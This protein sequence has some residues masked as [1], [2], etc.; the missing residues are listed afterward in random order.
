[1]ASTFS[2]HVRCPQCQVI[3]QQLHNQR[4]VLVRLLTQSVQLGNRVV[5]RRLRQS[6]RTVWRV[7]NLVVKHREVECQPEPDG[8]CRCQ[9]CHGNVRRSL[10]CHQAVLGRLFAVVAGCEFRLVAVV[11]TFPVTSKRH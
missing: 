9:L 7:E 1:M 2:L 5:E 10:V 11:V 8:V 6:A 4:R 3:P